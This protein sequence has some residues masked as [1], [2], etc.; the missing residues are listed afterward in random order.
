ML[1]NLK[2]VFS[3]LI[4]LSVINIADAQKT[5]QFSAQ[6]A[7]D[8]AMKNATE[9]KNALLDINIQKQSN[10]EFTSIA[11]PQMNSSINGSHYFD[12]PVTTLPD[13]ISPSVYNVLVN[14]GVRDGN[15]NPIQFPSGG[16]KSVP[17]IGRAHV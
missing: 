14:N 8:Y 1:S 11:L 12:I 6:Q 7:V 13:F 10:K 5:S 2:R 4:F 17:E 9:I 15:G 3:I 16:F